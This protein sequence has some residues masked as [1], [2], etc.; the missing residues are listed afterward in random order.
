MSTPFTLF[1]NLSSEAKKAIRANSFIIPVGTNLHRAWMIP[2]RFIEEATREH[3][4]GTLFASIECLVPYELE[5]IFGDA[6]AAQ[7]AYEHMI[8]VAKTDFA[9]RDIAKDSELR[10]ITLPLFTPNGESVA[11]TLEEDDT[12]R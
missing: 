10:T 11:V 3:D 4:V 2:P 6:Q 9:A 1:E 8:T 12:W 7:A 5:D